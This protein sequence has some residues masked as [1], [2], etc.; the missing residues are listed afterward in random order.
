[1]IFSSVNFTYRNTHN[2]YGSLYIGINFY[3]FSSIN[4]TFDARERDKVK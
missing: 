3:V 2:F 1:M 4:S